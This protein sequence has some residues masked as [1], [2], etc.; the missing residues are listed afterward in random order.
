MILLK[1]Q[2]PISNAMYKD[3]LHL[4]VIQTAKLF[5]NKV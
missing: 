2:D 4:N 3:L 1:W 5:Y